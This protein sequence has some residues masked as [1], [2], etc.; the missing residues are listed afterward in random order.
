M[1]E[2]LQL[3]G[4]HSGESRDPVIHRFPDGGA[5]PIGIRGTPA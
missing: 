3:Q 5:C 4:R 1:N 2:Q